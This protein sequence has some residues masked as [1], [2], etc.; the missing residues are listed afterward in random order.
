MSQV[1]VLAAASF[2]REP[3]VSDVDAISQDSNTEVAAR[4]ASVSE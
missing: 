2:Y 3:S 4:E 1:R